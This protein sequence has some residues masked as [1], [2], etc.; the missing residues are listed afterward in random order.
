MKAAITELRARRDDAEQHLH[1]L[2]TAIAVLQKLDGNGAA[3]TT[4]PPRR[5][6]AR[7]HLADARLPQRAGRRV[8]RRH[9]TR[10]RRRRARRG[11]GVTT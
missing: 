7:P 9:A 2:D 4:P 1:A 11:S 10:S 8:G 5:D 6:L 3:P